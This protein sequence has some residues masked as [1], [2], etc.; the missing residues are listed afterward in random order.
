MSRVLLDAEADEWVAVI[1]H[2]SREENQR[3]VPDG[4]QLV[5]L[6]AHKADTGVSVTLDG[7]TIGHL[8]ADLAYFHRPV[9]RICAAGLEMYAEAKIMEMHGRYE[10]VIPYIHPQ[11]FMRWAGR[12]ITA[13]RHHEAEK[14]RLVG[15][16]VPRIGSR[17]LAIAS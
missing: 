12:K 7:T 3:I 1:P 17:E 15:T 10:L 11:D 2:E 14:R 6:H 13:H 4:I 5:R 8:G 16:S 9:Q